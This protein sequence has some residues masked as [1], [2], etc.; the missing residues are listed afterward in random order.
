VENLLPHC[1][2]GRGARV[3]EKQEATTPRKKA[4][5]D[6]R[7]KCLGFRFKLTWREVSKV[8][9]FAR[10]SVGTAPPQHDKKAIFRAMWPLRVCPKLKTRPRRPAAGGGL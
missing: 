10:V 8:R 2:G 1:R 9:N 7:C 6:A 4:G 5:R 3:R